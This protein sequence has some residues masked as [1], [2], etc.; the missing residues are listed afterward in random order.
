MKIR[1]IEFPPVQAQSGLMNFTGKPYW[2]RILF[3]AFLAVP[4][5][6][7]GFVSKTTTL[8]EREGNMPLKEDWETPKELFSRCIWFNWFKAITLNA[9]GLS[10]P[11]LIGLLKKNKWQI[12]K[13]PFWISIMSVEKT[14]EA[15]LQEYKEIVEILYPAIHR[16][17]KS[18]CG[19]VVNF[20]CP[21]QKGVTQE[22]AVAESNEVLDL[23][24][25]LSVPIMVKLSV[26]TSPQ[27]AK[28]VADHPVCDGLCVSNTIPWGAKISW[29][30][31]DK[32]V[33]W[34][35]LFSLKRGFKIA[36]QDSPLWDRL[37]KEQA[38]GLSGPPIFPILLEW[39][40]RARETE[41]RC[42]ISAGGGV[43]SKDCIR[44][45][46]NAGADSIRLGTVCMHR[47]WRVWGMVNLANKLFASTEGQS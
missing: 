24:E 19:V 28:V 32:Q 42:H 18:R 1:G 8:E 5:K 15:R 4:Y 14:K 3:T 22:D 26:T 46:K 44:Q 38:G 43:F 2:Y 35:K 33:D 12:R 41:L 29:L 9:V 45:L 21:N 11:G 7:M 31:D 20:S 36:P 23:L 34:H 40:R 10:G 39:I 17:F 13:N 47:P 6:R 37:G 16:T 27:Q 25:K 30:T